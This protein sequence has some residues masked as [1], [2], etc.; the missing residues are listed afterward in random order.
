MKF[1]N[2]LAAF[3]ALTRL[4]VVVLLWML[5]PALVQKVV[6]RN[7]NKSLIEKKTNFIKHLDKEEIND[8][9][10]MNDTSETYA[11]YSTLH[12]EFLQ[13]SRLP[14]RA[15]TSKA[16]YM[17][18]PRVIEDEQ[19]DYRILQYD[20]NY[21]DSGYRL[22]IGNSLREIQ[23]L[24]V[25]IRWFFLIVLIGILGVTFLMDSFF[26]EYML[27]PFYRI[28]DKKIRRADQPGKFDPTPIPSRSSDFTELDAVLNQMMERINS[29]FLQ[30]RQFIGNVS[31]ELLTPI[32]LLKN[33]LEN[34]LQNA[35][36]DNDAIDKIAASLRT[37][38]ILKK[39]INNLLLISR[40][41][42]HQY[43]ANERI[44]IEEM[45]AGLSEDFED[46]IAEKD[47]SLSVALLPFEFTGNRTLMHILF[48]NLVSNAIK[49][50]KRK[51]SIS[52]TGKETWQDYQIDV[53]DSGRGIASDQI[54]KI[55]ERFTRIDSDQ[56]GQGIGLAIVKSVAD[57]HQID[58]SVESTPEIGTTFRLIIRKKS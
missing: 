57:F 17:T 22:E 37:L 18:A 31:H 12:S 40:I 3:N 29:V 19:N 54:G 52:V 48:Y 51:G 43:E 47:L 25:A 30:E 27:Q 1:R 20:F 35:S 46:R 33:R 41:E 26:I 4:L 34:L 14:A 2:Q 49:Y 36:L 28:I 50:N 38:D 53:S 16:I 11:S 6:Y 45:F 55:F 9:L 13:L 44:D 5:L 23:E 58:V 10:V 15:K 24:T 32:S 21:D 7:I 8:F 42:N 56:D 39:T